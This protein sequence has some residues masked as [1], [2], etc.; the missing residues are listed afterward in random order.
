MSHMTEKQH[1][2]KIA[3]HFVATL[4]KLLKAADLKPSH[5]SEITGVPTRTI[6]YWFAGAALPSL[7]RVNTMKLALQ[8]EEK[9]ARAFADAIAAAFGA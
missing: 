8:A 2:A 6:Q 1:E 3:K 7:D 4:K 9:A 5:L